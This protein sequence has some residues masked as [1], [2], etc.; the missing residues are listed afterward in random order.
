MAEVLSG[1]AFPSPGFLITYAT[2]TPTAHTTEEIELIHSHGGDMHSA[3]HELM[4]IREQMLLV[5]IEEKRQKGLHVSPPNLQ[6]VVAYAEWSTAG[7]TIFR[8]IRQLQ[9]S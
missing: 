7:L 8:Q 2:P 1:A 6:D 9:P 4:L 5:K 3:T